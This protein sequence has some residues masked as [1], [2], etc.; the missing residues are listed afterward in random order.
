MI[1]TVLST[2]GDFVQW[3]PFFYLQSFLKVVVYN[4]FLKSQAVKVAVTTCFPY[5]L[6][7]DAISTYYMCPSVR[8]SGMSAYI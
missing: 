1:P 2:H 5:L 8:P 7:R 3:N 6:R 4:V